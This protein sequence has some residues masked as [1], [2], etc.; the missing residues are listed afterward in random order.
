[1]ND[2]S[3]RGI[4]SSVGGV[5]NGFSREAGFDITM[6]SEVM[7]ILYLTIKRFLR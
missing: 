5:G 2:W 3:L 7:A 6:V 1:M 4:V